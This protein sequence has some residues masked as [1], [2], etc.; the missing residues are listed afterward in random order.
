MKLSEFIKQ[1]LVDVKTGVTEA[2]NEI[3]E[4][5]NYFTMETP[6]PDHKDVGSVHFDI[7][8]T[9]SSEKSGKSGGEINVVEAIKIGGKNATTSSEENTS[10]IKFAVQINISF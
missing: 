7:A 10:R 1:T 5:S 3:G 8:V 6:R 2:N 4:T 9:V